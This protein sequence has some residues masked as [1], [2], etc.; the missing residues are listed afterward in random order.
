MIGVLS[1]HLRLKCLD[2]GLCRAKSRCGIEARYSA[3]KG[4]HPCAVIV[5]RLK[6]NRCPDFEVCGRQGKSEAAWHN[7][8]D[9]VR[10]AADFD[11]V[12][13][14]IL[15]AAEVLAPDGVAEDDRLLVAGVGEAFKCA[16]EAGADG[17]TDAKDVEEVGANELMAD[18]LGTA[19]AFK[20][21]TSVGGT[22]EADGFEGAGVG[23]PLLYVEPGN[24]G[25]TAA[26]SRLVDGN[27]VLRIAVWEDLKQN[28]LDDG[29]H[30]E[31]GAEA[32]C[33]GG[34]DCE[35]E[36]GGA[37]HLAPCVAEVL[38][39]MFEP[40]T[41]PHAACGSRTRSGLPNSRSAARRASSG[42]A[43]RA[44]RSAVAMAMWAAISSSTSFTVR[45]Q[46]LTVC[47]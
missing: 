22:V 12:S 47:S 34:D 13:N 14:D 26:P 17:G 10:F 3:V 21:R 25:L 39:D 8:D 31:G 40:L 11:G 28:A 38:Q 29:E 42:S 27:E 6:C 4:S 45:R 32:E 2:L 43:P 44:M 36:G 33:E 18:L 41:C 16:S 19:V 9:R 20:K 46:S 5:F 7:T 15:T 23:P 1:S 24:L 30:G 35:G 37:A